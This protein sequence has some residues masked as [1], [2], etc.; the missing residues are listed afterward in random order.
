M[1]RNALDAALFHVSFPESSDP[2]LEVELPARKP[3]DL[4]PSHTAEV[5]SLHNRPIVGRAN[6][7]DTL[8]VL[9]VS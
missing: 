3:H 5:G 2:R 8:K 6:L 4:A 7:H 9:V 1:N